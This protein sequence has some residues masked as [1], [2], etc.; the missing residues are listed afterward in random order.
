MDLFKMKQVF[1][2]WK[3]IKKRKLK[4]LKSILNRK[5]KK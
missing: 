1:K 3:A 2:A 5:G 4:I